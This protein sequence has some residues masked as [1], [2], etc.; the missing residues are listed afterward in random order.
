M[1]LAPIIVYGSKEL[2]KDRIV[3]YKKKLPKVKWGEIDVAGTDFDE[4]RLRVG[5]VRWDDDVNGFVLHNIPDRKE[6]RSFL[7]DILNSSPVSKLIIWDSNRHIKYDHKKQGFSSKKWGDFVKE[8]K[9]FEGVKV[10][11]CGEDFTYRDIYEC[12]EHVQSLFAAKGKEIGQESAKILIDI[13]GF[14]KAVLSSEVEKL[15]IASPKKVSTEYVIENAFPITK[16]AVIFKI[17]EALNKADYENILLTIED[18]VDSGINQNV[19]IDIILKQIRWQMVAAYYIFTKAP[20]S[21]IINCLMNMGKFPS[22]IWHDKTLSANEKKKVSATFKKRDDFVEYCVKKYRMP[23]YYFKPKKRD[24]KGEVMSYRDLASKTVAFVNQNFISPNKSKMSEHEVRTKTLYRY[25]NLYVFV[26]EK[27]F[28]IR[29][30]ENVDQDLQEV[31]VKYVDF[32]L[33]KP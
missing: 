7:A 33:D 19:I 28:E 16:D 13:V 1:N 11:N 14:N 25:M 10:I 21:E 26:N 23:K 32:S 5:T 27:L 29:K 18:L 15:C 30:G 31:V 24:A 6:A 17:Y 8:A 12:V 9:T 4:I 22:K 3:S 20:S 2:A